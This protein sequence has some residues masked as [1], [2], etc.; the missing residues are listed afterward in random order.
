MERDSL[1]SLLLDMLSPVRDVPLSHLA[2]LTEADWQALLGMAKQHRLEPLLHW[3]LGQ[4]NLREAIPAAHRAVLEQGFR[5]TAIRSLHLQRELIQIHKILETASIPYIALKGAALAFHV[6]PHPA[7]RPLRD[8]DILV[9]RTQ[10][11]AAHQAFMDSGAKTVDGYSLNPE[12]TLSIMHHL[13]PL[14]VANGQI[15][16]ELHAHLFHRK[17]N[18]EETTDLSDTPDFWSRCIQQ[19]VAGT[20]LTFPSDTDLLL[21]LIIHA[22]YD[23]AFNN[24]PLLLSDLA[25]LIQQGGVD[26][27]LFW[28]LAEQ[29]GMLKGCVLALRLMEHYYG[30]CPVNWPVA[31]PATVDSLLLQEAARLMLCDIDARGIA[32]LACKL[33]PQSSSWEKMRMLLGRAFPP[34]TKIAWNYPV[35]ADSPLIYCW[36]PVRWWRLA[37]RTLPAYLEIQQRSHTQSEVNRLKQLKQWL[38]T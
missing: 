36:Y 28:Q 34:K 1:K 3:Q 18:G 10:I 15:G 24:G 32:K 27:P 22:V 17:E 16:I 20:P 11:L 5:R 25:L 30:K 14:M 35:A 2:S 21:H 37:T 29:H 19:P 4:K 9:P 23:H 6:Y 13:S 33:P 8:L 7:L 26:W 12:V 31:M 38:H